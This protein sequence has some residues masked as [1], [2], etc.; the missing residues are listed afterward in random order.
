MVAKH[1][2]VKPDRIARRG[3]DLGR[4]AEIDIAGNLFLCDSPKQKARFSVEKMSGSKLL[5]R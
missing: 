2:L 1:H 4:V 3:I 5:S